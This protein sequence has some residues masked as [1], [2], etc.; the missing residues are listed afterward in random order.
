MYRIFFL[1]LI[2]HLVACRRTAEPEIFMI[3]ENYKGVIVVVF[4][5]AS[6]EEIFYDGGRRV[7][8]IP[9]NGILRTKFKKTIHGKINQ[10]YF[11]VDQNGNKTTKIESFNEDNFLSGKTYILFGSYGEVRENGERLLQ[12]ALIA[13]GAPESRDSL[14]A[15]EEDILRNS[16]N[17][18]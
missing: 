4:N 18:E 8:S 1:I 11:Y 3:P 6:G 14:Y 10:Q 16:I 15:I 7:Y 17:E 12:Y 9:K 13:I 2:L 5:Q